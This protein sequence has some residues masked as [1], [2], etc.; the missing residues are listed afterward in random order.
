MILKDVA[1]VGTQIFVFITSNINLDRIWTTLHPQLRRPIPMADIN[2]DTIPNLSTC[3]KLVFNTDTSTLWTVEQ[4]HLEGSE[5]WCWRRTQRISWYDR[6]RNEVL[7]T[8]KEERNIL[9]RIKRRTTNWICHILRKNCL[10]K[11]IMKG[12]IEG[13][14]EVTRRQGRICKQLLHDLEEAN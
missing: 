6:V 14:I 3:H 10:L 13:T 9:Q 7:R 5:M 4:K 1:S 2:T 11:H 12:K 8:V